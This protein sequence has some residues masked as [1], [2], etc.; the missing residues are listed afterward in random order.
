MYDVAII[1][2]GAVG[3]I[4]AQYLT[5]QGKRTLVLEQVIYTTDCWIN[6]SLKYIFIMPWCTGIYSSK[7]WDET[8]QE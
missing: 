1:G 6:T 2:G 3:L 8:T 4:A 7:C 5:Q